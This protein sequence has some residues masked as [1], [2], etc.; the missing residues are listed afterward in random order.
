MYDFRNTTQ[1][2]F[3]LE[4]K[5]QMI[6]NGVNLDEKISGFRTL[7]VYGRELVSRNIST[8]DYRRVKVGSTMRSYANKAASSTKSYDNKFLGA[9]LSSR[10][11]S[12]EYDLK[13]KNNKEFI[14]AFEILNY[15][16]D[17]EQ[18]EIIF[19]DDKNFFW[20]GTV[21][22]TEIPD[23]NNLWLK[24]SFEIECPNPFKTSINSEVLEF[25]TRGKLKK[26]TLYP[27]KLERMKVKLRTSGN[28][29]II[30]NLNNA[31]SIILNA[32]F[33]TGDIFEIDFT[34]SNINKNLMQYLDMTSDLEEFEVLYNDE[35]HTSLPC[36]VGLMYREVR[37]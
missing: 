2:A 13:A 30:K 10:T 18:A 5:V 20:V 27:V 9:T 25:D 26:S 1:S 35:L 36:D 15:Y 8:T 11:L 21:S 33:K 34:N 4:N 6:I 28:K 24:S 32:P 3:P 7:A 37:L 17:Q 29:L 14:E 19:T 31:Q 22:E 16:L 12:V 23:V